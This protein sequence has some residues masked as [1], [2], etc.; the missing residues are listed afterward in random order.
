MRRH[1]HNLADPLLEIESSSSSLRF[2]SNANWLQAHFL[3]HA[4]HFL[5]FTEQPAGNDKWPVISS[6]VSDRHII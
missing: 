2:S 3:D 6:G 5:S 1:R 4:L